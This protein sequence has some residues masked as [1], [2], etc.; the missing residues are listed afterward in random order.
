MAQT[1]K[2]KPKVLEKMTL[3]ELES[4][5]FNT[6]S[7][8]EFFTD[9]LNKANQDLINIAKEIQKRKTA[10]LKQGTTKVSAPKPVKIKNNL[11]SKATPAKKK[12]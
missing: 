3:Q 4:L 5:G 9:Q 7:A 12:K 1:K 2:Q 10:E 8:K 6:Y 11:Q